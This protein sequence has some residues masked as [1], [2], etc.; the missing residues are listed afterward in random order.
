MRAICWTSIA[1]L[2]LAANAAFAD[3][4]ALDAAKPE[5][6]A[7]LTPA[8]EALLDDFEFVSRRSLPDEIPVLTYSDPSA[9]ALTNLELRRSNAIERLAEIRRLPLLTLAEVGQARLFFGV[10]SDGRLGLHF[11]ASSRK[12]AE[13]DATATELASLRRASG[14]SH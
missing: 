2:G 14:L 10:S 9:A 8:A 3:D 7:Q 1:V 13:N 11:G 6:S 4:T 12:P 5:P